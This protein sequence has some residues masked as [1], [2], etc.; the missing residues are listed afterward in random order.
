MNVP[1]TTNNPEYPRAPKEMQ[2]ILLSGRI[3]VISYAIA[4]KLEVAPIR[5]LQLFYESD[6]CRRLHEERTGLYLFGD[7]Y[8]VDEFMLEMQGRQ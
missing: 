8:I 6:T 2:L 1:N 4:K 5:A 3:G 7:W